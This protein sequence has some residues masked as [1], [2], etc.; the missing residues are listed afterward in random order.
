MALT[1]V[2]PTEP[3]PKAE[4]APAPVV[5]PVV[6]EPV[7]VSDAA[8]DDLGLRV[9]PFEL[10]YDLSREVVVEADEE[11]FDPTIEAERAA[12]VVI[13]PEKKDL[14]LGEAPLV[15]TEPLFT[16]LPSAERREWWRNHFEERRAAAKRK[17]PCIELP[18]WLNAVLKG[19][20]RDAAVTGW[21]RAH[22]ALPE[23]LASRPILAT[24]NEEE[25][26]RIL[27][28]LPPLS[29]PMYTLN[30]NWW[31]FT[32]VGH[33]IRAAL[34]ALSAEQAWRVLYDIPEQALEA[35]YQVTALVSLLQPTPE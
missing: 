1:P 17:H 26:Q 23:A 27:D 29:E 24:L 34:G 11:P 4:P 10:A 16:T 14:Y 19:G 35:E 28:S 6:V 25:R 30:R 33:F 12:R 8:A 5:E 20:I 3:T 32:N 22:D 7:V 9:T 15:T 18:H 13:P 31:S 2:A 21:V